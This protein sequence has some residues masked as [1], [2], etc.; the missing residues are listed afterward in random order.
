MPSSCRW[1]RSRSTWTTSPRR[2]A[3]S[4]RRWLPKAALLNASYALFHVPD[5]VRYG[6]KPSREVRRDP[7]RLKDLQAHLRSFDAA[8]DYPPNQVFLGN[9]APDELAA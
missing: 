9:L 8:R 7:A 6:S 5:L 2:Y 1:P 3:A 4:A